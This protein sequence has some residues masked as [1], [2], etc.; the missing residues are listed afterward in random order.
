MIYIESKS[1][2]PYY[3]LALEEYVFEHMDRSNEYFMLWQNEKTVVVGKYQ[4]TAQ[5]INREFVRKHGIRVVRRLSGGGAV[6]HDTGNLNFTFIVDQREGFDFNFRRFA[7]PVAETLAD[8]GIRAEFTGRNDLVIEGR[9]FSG[10]SQ[11]IRKGRILHHG[12]IMISSDIQD[13]ASALRP[14]EAK[15]ESK[16]AKSVRSRVTTVSEAAGRPV[17][18][19][20]FKDALKRHILAKDAENH[21]YEL[22]PSD[23]EAVRKLAADKYS[24]WEWNYG[25]SGNY[26]YAVSQR[27]EFGTVE[28]SARIENGV[29]REITINGDFFGDGEIEE[30]QRMLTGET[31]DE[32]LA[33]RIS[34]KTDI[35][36]YIRGMTAGDMQQLL[37]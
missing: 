2:D 4:N 15:F 28:I 18:V 6:Y 16:S 32:N 24:S 19:S 17:S 7:L 9:K 12:C 36:R 1:T 29:I 3:N 11:Y 8:M 14:K 10:N 31:L 33:E 13:V 37:L 30:L 35:S 34:N 26:N 23:V 21:E 5:E 22:T 20:A 25:K 27:Y